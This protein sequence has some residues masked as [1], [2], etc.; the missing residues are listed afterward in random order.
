MKTL[1]IECSMGAAGDM[2]M[3]ALCELLQNPDSFIDQMN[4]ILPENVRLSRQTADACGIHGTQI[5]VVINGQEEASDDVNSHAHNH[6]HEHHHRHEHMHEHHHHA[7][8]A[9]IEAVI[10]H[11]TVSDKVKTD[12]T[13]V[14]RL[15]AE[16]ESQAHGKPVS[17]IHFHEVGT[18]DAVADITGVCL[19][20]E[21]LA[22]EKVVVSP[23][24]V[25]KGHVR[26][27]HG[28]LPVPAPA[29]AYILQNVPIYSGSIEGELC[30]P[31]G[32]ALLKYFAH[33]FGT[34]PIMR[35]SAVGYG[36]GKKHFETAN[37]VRAF[38]GETESTAEQILELKCN[39]DDMTPEDIGFAM[40]QLLSAGALDVFTAPIGMKKNR[41][42]V[43][44]TCLCRPEDREAM[45]HEI[46]LHTSTI[47]VRESSCRRYVLE[48]RESTHETPYGAVRVK[49]VSGYGVTRSKPEYDDLAELA[50]KN[51]VSIANV[52][53]EL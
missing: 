3:S 7:T 25:G 28:I 13:S 50:Q 39:L 36:I 34:M 14:Y 38:W 20:M 42:A 30:T 49:Q 18:M 2:L 47:G 43:L 32:A 53:K 52:R 22:P 23:I 17:E 11:L 8:M 24:H 35:T 51:N 40:E 10:N 44:L 46:F 4:A 48:R 27:A 45:L 26:C 19:L 9:D 1:Y 41:P 31:T 33:E 29:T 15:I 12:V 6:E 21:T 37:C 5:S 16:A